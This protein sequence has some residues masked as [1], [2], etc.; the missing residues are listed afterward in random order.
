MGKTLSSLKT[1]RSVSMDNLKSEK[2]CLH[3]DPYN[4]KHFTYESVFFPTELVL[5]GVGKRDSSSRLPR[6]HYS[7]VP[8]QLSTLCVCV[9]GGGGG[10]GVEGGRSWKG[11]RSLAS[12]FWVYYM[13]DMVECSLMPHPYF[14]VTSPG[15][16]SAVVLS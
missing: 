6:D 15:I 4:P 8:A 16:G 3:F 5:L 1:S 9:G 10:G 13:I 7:S 12:A 14:H 2:N 11:R